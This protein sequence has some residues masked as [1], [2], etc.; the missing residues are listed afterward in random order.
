M[1]IKYGE[2]NTVIS[3]ELTFKP[4]VF[5]ADLKSFKNW[6]SPYNDEK[7]SEEQINEIVSFISNSDSQTKVVFD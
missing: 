3:G 6:D 7:I 2:R 5:Y 1:H 4:P